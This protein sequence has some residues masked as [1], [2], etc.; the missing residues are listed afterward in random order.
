MKIPNLIMIAFPFLFSLNISAQ[1][2]ALDTLPYALEYHHERLDIFKKEVVV[3]G[4]MVFLGDSQIEFGNWGKHL[5]D[6]TIINRGI[7]GDNTYGV[8]ARLN[9]VLILKP[10]QIILEVGIN[11]I[12]KNIPDT[13]VFKNILEIVKKIKTNSPQ[14]K[15]FVTSLFPTNDAVAKEYP[16]AF[17]KNNHVENINNLLKKASIN[18]DFIFLDLH[19]LLKNF[20]GKLNEQFADADGLHLNSEGYKLWV[21]VIKKNYVNPKIYIKLSPNES[22]L[23]AALHGNVQEIKMAIAK[24]AEVN[25]KDKNGNTPLNMVAKLSYYNL[26]K[27][28]VEKGAE[29]NTSNND[30]ITPLHYGVEYNNIKIVQ[31]LLKKGANIDARDSINE[32]P[33][34]W[35]GWTGN[36]EAARLLLKYGANPYT[37]NNTDVTPLFN[38][39]RQEHWQLERIFKKSKYQKKFI[40]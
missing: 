37:P 39:I 14:T 17:N 33:L 21:D 32:T 7:A 2:V 40:Q 11:D 30:H 26:V 20:D 36:I 13:F 22:L 38:A 16:N 34:H 10:N 19:S 24:G 35:A 12:G 28:F 23:A 4:K 27:Y 1:K 25:C 29:V 18:G 8:L 3:M 6:T 31:L 15:T 5:K 9:D